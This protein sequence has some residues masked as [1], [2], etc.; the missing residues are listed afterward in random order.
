MAVAPDAGLILWPR[1][2]GG[3]LDG[4]AQANP[5]EY[6]HFGNMA[7]RRDRR[8]IRFAYCCIDRTT[9]NESSIAPA[10]NVVSLL[11]NVCYNSAKPLIHED[12]MVRQRLDVTD[13]IR[14]GTARRLCNSNNLG[15]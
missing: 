7:R 14:P 5:A 13:Q 4:L 6:F 9:K 2:S 1:S 12:A 10:G 3:N 8:M 11:P 15:D